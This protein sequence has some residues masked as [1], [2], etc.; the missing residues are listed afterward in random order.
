MRLLGEHALAECVHG[1][2]AHATDAGSVVIST[3][4]L[5][6]GEGDELAALLGDAEI[7][8]RLHALRLTGVP[9]VNEPIV[10]VSTALVNHA[11]ACA[12]LR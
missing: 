11:R 1:P 9:T 7:E 6:L 12:A 3:A 4:R 10:A 8:T 2:I 5:A